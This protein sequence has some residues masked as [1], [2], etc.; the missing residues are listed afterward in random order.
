MIKILAS[1][2]TAIKKN[3]DSFK[4]VFPVHPRTRRIIH[5]FKINFS[6]IIMNDPL[7]YLEFTYLIKI[8]KGIFADSGGITEEA[9]VFNI[10]CLTI[11]NSTE[12]P[13]AV[14]VGTNELIGNDLNKLS[15]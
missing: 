11:R 8:A 6:N 3:T 2:L 10:L 15:E 1:I 12:R 13:E 9:T 4:I 7:G 5:Q 14:T